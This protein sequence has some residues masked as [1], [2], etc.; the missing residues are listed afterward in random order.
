M[1]S[2]LNLHILTSVLGVSKESRKSEFNTYLQKNFGIRKQPLAVF[3]D[4]YS[5]WDDSS[6]KLRMQ[7]ELNKLKNCIFNMS[8]FLCQDAQVNKILRIVSTKRI[9]TNV[10]QKAFMLIK[11]LSEVHYLSV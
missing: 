6:E 4:N 7:E 11:E 8:T 1:I 9:L 2:D 10:F 3:L 5:D